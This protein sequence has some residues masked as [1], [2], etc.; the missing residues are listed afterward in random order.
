MPATALESRARRVL[1]GRE[2]SPALVYARVP[3]QEVELA[4]VLAAC[5]F[6][7]VDTTITLGR[8]EPPAGG[9]PP[10]G[11]EVDWARPEQAPALL[12]IAESAF[13]YSRFHQDPHLPLRQAHALKRAWLQNALAGRRGRGV[14]AAEEGGRVLGFLIVLEGEEGGRPLWVVDLMG[15]ARDRQGRGVGRALLDRFCTLA[16]GRG[17]AVRAGTQAANLPALR[18]YLSLGFAPLATELILHAH[19]G[20]EGT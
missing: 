19:R 10:A 17:A 16:A 13:R 6:Y 7:L 5:G 12:E 2:S 11:L 9:K 20:G 4:R 8:P 14:L 15:V 18:L 3:E 1:A